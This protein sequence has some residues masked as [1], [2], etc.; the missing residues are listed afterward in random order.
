MW[1]FILVSAL[2]IMTG[3][4]TSRPLARQI[5]CRWLSSFLHNDTEGIFSTS[6]TSIIIWWSDI[7]LLVLSSLII[8][9]RISSFTVFKLSSSSHYLMSDFQK[10]LCIYKTAECGGHHHLLQPAGLWYAAEMPVFAGSKQWTGCDIRHWN[11]YQQLSFGDVRYAAIFA[12]AGIGT[13][14]L[15]LFWYLGRS[16]WKTDLRFGDQARGRRLPNAGSFCKVL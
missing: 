16:F 3:L 2:V 1:L 4:V 7:N 13:V 14:R 9:Y 15:V 12:A 8:P 5:K 6:E 11:S 10:L